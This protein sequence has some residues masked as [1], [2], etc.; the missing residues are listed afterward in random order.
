MLSWILYDKN[1][2]TFFSIFNGNICFIN[3]S[4]CLSLLGFLLSCQGPRFVVRGILSFC[5]SRLLVSL[6]L[7]AISCSVIAQ[8]CFC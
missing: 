5:L 1:S 2:S 7:I 4:V 3:L 6:G 8:I